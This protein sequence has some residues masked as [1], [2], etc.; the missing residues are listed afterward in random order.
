MSKAVTEIHFLDPTKEGLDWDTD[1]SVIEVGNSKYRLC[2]RSRRS[3]KIENIKG[4][5][6]VSFTLPTGT[7]KVML[8]CAS[9]K[10]DYIVW[11][12]WN[13]AGKDFMLQYVIATNTVNIVLEDPNPLNFDPDS[14]IFNSKIIGDDIL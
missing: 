3:G 4:N 6:L 2:C 11:G 8:S 13:G 1:P 7:N 10:E 5:T 9:T 12:V 14:L